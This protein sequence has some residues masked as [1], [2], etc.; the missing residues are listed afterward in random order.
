MRLYSEMSRES[1]LAAAVRRFTK[2]GYDST[3]LAEI[4]GDVGIRKP[5]LYAHFPGKKDIFLTLLKEAF[6]RE[7]DF[8]LELQGREATI[9][10]NLKAYLHAIPER[11]ASDLYFPFWLRV[12]YFPPADLKSDIAVYDRQ[13]SLLIDEGL[14]R[15]FLANFERTD[16]SLSLPASRDAMICILRGV[17]AELLYRGGDAILGRISAACQIIDLLFVE[18]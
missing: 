4:A 3:S 18:K 9:R 12:L 17:H 7:N 2:Q 8:I 10:K 11:Y 5:S 16:F 13:Y 14:D 15:L 1:I 6:Q